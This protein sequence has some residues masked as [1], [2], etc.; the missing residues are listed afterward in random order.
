MRMVAGIALAVAFSCAIAAE[1]SLPAAVDL[2]KDAAAARKDKLPVIVLVSLKGCP[3]CEAVRRSH[4]LPLTGAMPPVAILRQVEIKG[5]AALV[6]FDGKKVTHGDFA[7]K[8]RAA[9]APMVLFF[10]PEGRRAA[11]PLV[12]SSIA[13]FYGAY[14]EARLAEARRAA[15]K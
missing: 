3:H 14:F 4:L 1:S 2:S 12:G 6:D 8:H 7:R 9:I 11:E 5:G 13:D 10:D 15:G